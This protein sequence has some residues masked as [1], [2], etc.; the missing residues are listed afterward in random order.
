MGIE[1]FIRKVCVQTAVY[2]GNPVP[3]GFGGMIFDYPVEIMVRWDFTQRAILSQLQVG[4][5]VDATVLSPED[6]ECEGMLFLGTLDDLWDESVTSSGGLIDPKNFEGDIYS[7]LKV[8]KVAMP[9]KTT[10]AVKTYSLSKY[11]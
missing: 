8:E 11:K 9:K 2:W 5:N 3:D 4:L 10:F 1:S 7:I 6:L